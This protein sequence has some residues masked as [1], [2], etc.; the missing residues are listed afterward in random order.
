MV[1][2]IVFL[3]LSFQ[4]VAM[5][6]AESRKL[7]MCEEAR[8]YF[9]ASLFE[10]KLYRF[11]GVAYGEWNS[12]ALKGVSSLDL[13]KLALHTDE[14]DQIHITN[15]R[16]R[17]SKSCDLFIKQLNENPHL[18][19]KFT[20][21]AE[22]IIAGNRPQ[23]VLTYINE[24]EG[25]QLKL[26]E[27]KTYLKRLLYTRNRAQSEPVLPGHPFVTTPAL[28]RPTSLPEEAFHH[29]HAISPAPLSAR[30]L[31]F[32]DEPVIKAVANRAAASGGAASSV[33]MK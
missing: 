32:E 30:I 6:A 4:S 29:A 2:Y 22:A 17:A 27:P 7:T 24:R 11:V 3:L 13:V 8:K 25:Q 21:V 12:S 19:H 28:I 18:A 16:L 10:R 15:D 33:E 14:Y 23:R 20:V 26:E 31:K 1:I 5:N 9:D